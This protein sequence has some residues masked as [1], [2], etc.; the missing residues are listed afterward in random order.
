MK[1]K[2]P[3]S[4]GR[5]ERLVRLEYEG[6]PRKL[7]A[8]RDEARRELHYVSDRADLER[9]KAEWELEELRRQITDL[10]H[11]NC[12]MLLKERDEWKKESEKWEKA[13]DEIY[14]SLM[15]EQKR[16]NYGP[17]ETE[18]ECVARIVRERDEARRLAEE[19]R[20]THYSYCM[21]RDFPKLPWEKDK[22]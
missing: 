21:V 14:D 7:E 3:A 11:P 5:M 10:S 1:N 19:Y 16:D 2:L 20:N 15:C 4:P 6:K 18:G 8:E 13:Y 9:E 22:P 17:T 12:Q